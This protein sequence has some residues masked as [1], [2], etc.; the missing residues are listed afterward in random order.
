MDSCDW[1]TERFFS[2]M[3]HNFTDEQLLV[4]DN[5]QLHIDLRSRTSELQ[6][7]FLAREKEDLRHFYY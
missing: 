2:C 7:S 1:I 4:N 5:T 6:L 3:L